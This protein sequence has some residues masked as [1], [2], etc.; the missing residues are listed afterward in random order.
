MTVI[1][2]NVT[3]W[4]GWPGGPGISVFYATQGG[5]VADKLQIFF[6]AVKS[7]IVGG[8]V[9]TVAQSGDSI[10]DT[11]G[12]IVGTWTQSNAGPVTCTAAGAFAPQTGARVRWNTSGIENGRRVRGATFLVPVTSSSLSNTGALLGSSVTTIQAAASALIVSGAGHQVIWHRPSKKGPGASFP[13]TS[14]TCLTEVANLRSRR[15]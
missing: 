9:I 12:Q 15:D 14:A 5:G 2:R 8:V 7:L 4:T 6:A 1:D 13:I 3:T 11:T 10:D